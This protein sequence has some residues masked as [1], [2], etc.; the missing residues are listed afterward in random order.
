MVEIGADCQT[1]PQ[2]VVQKCSEDLHNIPDVGMINIFLYL[3][4]IWQWP[5]K[6]LKSIKTISVTNCMKTIISTKLTV[7]IGKN[8]CNA[9]LPYQR[10]KPK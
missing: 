8:V 5:T 10:N 7:T 9:E 2:H 6:P 3:T 1:H 4:S